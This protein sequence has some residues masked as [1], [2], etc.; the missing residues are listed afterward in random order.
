MSAN[1][2]AADR[3]QCRSE[4]GGGGCVDPF[5]HTLIVVSPTGPL[6]GDGYDPARDTAQYSGLSLAEYRKREA[7][8]LV[9]VKANAEAAAYLTE[10]WT[11]KAPQVTTEESFYYGLNVL[12]PRDWRSIGGVEF[13][14]VGEPY[15]FGT[16]TYFAR[17][18]ERYLTARLPLSMPA[19][20]KV[21]FFT[22]VPQ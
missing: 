14:A 6:P 8:Y 9:T 10:A 5:S 11:D 2:V 4:E 17:V 13:F 19:A 21:A 7:P 20:A 3:G 1:P 18:G 12:P 16:W 22:K 15:G